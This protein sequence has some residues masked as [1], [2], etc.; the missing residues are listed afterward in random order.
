MGKSIKLENIK[1][2]LTNQSAKSL[3]ILIYLQVLK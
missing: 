1:G 2:T 3:N